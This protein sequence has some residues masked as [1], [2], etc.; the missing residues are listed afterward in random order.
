LICPLRHNITTFSVA[1]DNPSAAAMVGLYRVH[2]PRQPACLEFGDKQP[3]GTPWQSVSV[4]AVD[5]AVMTATR[6]SSSVS[7][8][9]SWIE[10]GHF[11]C[12]FIAHSLGLAIGH[13]PTCILLLILQLRE[14]LP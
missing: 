1:I 8:G 7:F 2:D 4:D 13:L 12:Q 10:V 5:L 9:K 14:P 11:L 6:T 3:V